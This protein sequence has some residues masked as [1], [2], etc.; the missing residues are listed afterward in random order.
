MV[1]F[2]NKTTKNSQITYYFKAL[3]MK[4]IKTEQ[5]K[6]GN[7]TLPFAINYLLN[8]TTTSR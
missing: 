7:K 1:K 8:A 5:N 3:T 2:H 4:I 6:K